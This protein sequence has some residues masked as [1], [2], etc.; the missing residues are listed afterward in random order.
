MW[1]TREA[2]CLHCM[3]QNM[4][5]SV[6]GQS[7][8]LLLHK[9]EIAGGGE[10]HMKD[11]MKVSEMESNTSCTLSSLLVKAT[12]PNQ[13]GICLMDEFYPSNGYK[14]LKNENIDPFPKFF[15]PSNENGCYER[16]WE[17]SRDSLLP[18]DSENMYLGFQSQLNCHS[19]YCIY[20]R[21][22]RGRS[23]CLPIDVQIQN[24][25][26]ISS[27]IKL[28]FS[29]NPVSPH[30]K[31]N[32]NIFFSACCYGHSG[33]LVLAI[34]TSKCS[35]VAL[36]FIWKFLFVF[37]LSLGLWF[38]TAGLWPKNDLQVC[39]HRV[40]DSRRKKKKKKCKY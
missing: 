38:S 40:S 30:S 35:I 15:H 9:R 7:D 13:K 28:E 16:F 6:S 8:S 14:H 3:L 36:E 23:I 1:R 19:V 34:I 26:D 22:K 12:G 32:K 25:L 5:G 24:G 37:L 10:R 29:L 21:R 31:Q 27:V 2:H 33:L 11:V 4:A 17:G 18:D 39:F 20:Y